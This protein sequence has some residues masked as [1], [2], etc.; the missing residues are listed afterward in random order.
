MWPSLPVANHIADI[1]NLFFIGSLVVGVVSTVTIVWMTG[2]K[3]AYW[4]EDRRGSAER[5]AALTTDT[6]QANARAADANARALQAQAELAR[7]KAPRSLPDSDKSRLIAL[8]SEF[9]GTNAAVYILGEGPEPAILGLSIKD[10]LTQSRWSVDTWTWTGAGAAAGVVVLF[11]PGSVPEIEA[12][13][14]SIVR[15]LISVHINSKK[16]PW[17]GPD[18]NQFPGMLNGPPSPATAPIRIIIGTKPQ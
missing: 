11:K 10:I 18:W 13:C 2:V 3:E 4:E 15:G 5:I 8:W 9:A 7:F 12:A 17:P 6:A 14:D 1:A 16:E